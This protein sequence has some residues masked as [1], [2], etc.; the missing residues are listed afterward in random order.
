MAPLID[1]VLAGAGALAGLVLL[2][3]AQAELPK[4]GDLHEMVPGDLKCVCP[5]L[6]ATACLRAAR[7]PRTTLRRT[8]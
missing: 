3:F 7:S 4:L 5:P 8:I 1:S 2:T 6:A